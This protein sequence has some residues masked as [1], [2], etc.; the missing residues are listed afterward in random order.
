MKQKTGVYGVFRYK[1]FPKRNGLDKLVCK[2]YSMKDA[3]NIAIKYNTDA[4]YARFYWREIEPT[5][6][7][8]L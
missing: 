4:L 8:I 6:I 7:D 5:E 1:E 2:T 3:I